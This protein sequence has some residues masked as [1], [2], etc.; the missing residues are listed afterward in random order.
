MGRNR[1]P[2]SPQAFGSTP[3]VR[4]VGRW[5]GPRLDGNLEADFLGMSYHSGIDF[6]E[7]LEG[8]AAG[9]GGVIRLQDSEKGVTS[10]L[11][12]GTQILLQGRQ[13]S[14]PLADISRQQPGRIAIT[15]AAQ[16]QPQTTACSGDLLRQQWCVDGIEAVVGEPF[17]EGIEADLSAEP[18]HSR[19][20]LESH[21]CVP[22]PHVY[23]SARFT[24]Q[25]GWMQPLA[26]PID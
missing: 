19:R 20:K 10:M 9:H 13:C 12:D 5:A 6:C 17:G 15:A 21:A 4:I 1:C 8:F 22:P 7:Y 25:P 16:R 18:G 14:A 24:D 2:G 3:Q 26:A 11:G 23:R